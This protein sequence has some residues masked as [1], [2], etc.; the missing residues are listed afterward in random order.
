MIISTICHKGVED[1]RSLLVTDSDEGQILL[2][3]M[4][5]YCENNKRKKKA[6]TLHKYMEENLQCF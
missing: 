2:E 1:G 4:R 3:A 6:K 5:E